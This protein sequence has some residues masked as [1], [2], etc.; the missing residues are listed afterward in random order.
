MFLWPLQMLP[1]TY[2]LVNSPT[3]TP[4]HA[5]PACECVSVCG[6][7]SNVRECVLIPLGRLVAR[8]TFAQTHTVRLVHSQYTHTHTHR[9]CWHWFVY[10][11]PCT[12]SW[13]SLQMH[14][15]IKLTLKLT[16]RFHNYGSFSSPTFCWCVRYAPVIQAS[17][18]LFFFPN[19]CI[20]VCV[21][22]ACAH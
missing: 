12:A 14:F 8:I 20:C 22:N 9:S 1:L 10:S 19:K 16:F 17:S 2:S 7:I 18:V 15:V 4:V 21:Y 3:R 13:F 6:V 11:E 5:C